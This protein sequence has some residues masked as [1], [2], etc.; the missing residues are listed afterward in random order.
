ME[1]YVFLRTSKAYNK[2]INWINLL[3]KSILNGCLLIT[4]LIILLWKLL[5]LHLYLRLLIHLRLLLHLRLL[6]HLRLLLHMRILLHL[7]WLHCLL[8]HIIWCKLESIRRITLILRLF[9]VR[10]ID[11]WKTRMF[12]ILKLLCQSILIIA[13]LRFAFLQIFR[14]NIYLINKSSSN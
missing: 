5:L 12:N 9:F 1:Y 4:L 14:Y 8:D 10:L 7:L 11:S 6:I 3:I 13:C 2:N